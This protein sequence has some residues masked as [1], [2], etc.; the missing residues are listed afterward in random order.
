MN[1]VKAMLLLTGVVLASGGGTSPAAAAE[2]REGTT[3]EVRAIQI[4]HSVCDPTA[5]VCEQ[6]GVERGQGAS[7]LPYW[8]SGHQFKGRTVCVESTRALAPLASARNDYLAAT[9]NTLVLTPETRLNGCT[10]RGYP[11]PQQIRVHSYSNAA[12]GWCGYASTW[13]SGAYVRA[14]DIY[15]NEHP[16]RV[17]CRTAVTWPA[18]F[19]HEIGHAAGLNHVPATENSM[20]PE[21]NNGKR[22]TPQVDGPRL[23]NIYANNP[24]FGDG[25]P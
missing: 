23:I 22:V 12:D 6:Q 20:M 16:S 25:A 5:A 17:G 13:I 1:K 2:R 8:A 14:A 9:K 10:S 15:I 3:A 4:V 24:L 18:L 7:A 19:E 21:L 11:I